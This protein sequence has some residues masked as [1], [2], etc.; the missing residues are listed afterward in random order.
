M[1]K[2]AVVFVVAGALTAAAPSPAGVSSGPPN[3]GGQCASASH[4]QCASA[5]H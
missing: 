3:S 1:R 2:L 5:P 4:G